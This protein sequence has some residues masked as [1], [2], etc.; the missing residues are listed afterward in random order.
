MHGAS[1]HLKNIAPTFFV[2]FDGLFSQGAI[3]I[4]VVDLTLS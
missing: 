1:A 2:N 3:Q 4:K